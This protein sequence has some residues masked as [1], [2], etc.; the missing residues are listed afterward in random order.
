MWAYT[1]DEPRFLSSR[2]KARAVPPAV[3]GHLSRLNPLYWLRAW[4]RHEAARTELYQ[5][6]QRELSDL[7]ITQGD[8]PAIL[9]GTFRREQ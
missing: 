9:E 8:I 3:G 1:N 7:G 4:M 5:L 2:G 6:D